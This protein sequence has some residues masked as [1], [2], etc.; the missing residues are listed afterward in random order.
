M[1][2]FT[3][4]GAA[5]DRWYVSIELSLCAEANLSLRMQDDTTNLEKE[6]NPRCVKCGAFCW[7][8]WP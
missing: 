4:S 7:P 5:S 3:Y 1:I 8:P 2:T 6:A